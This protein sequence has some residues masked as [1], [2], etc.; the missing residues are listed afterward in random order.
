M[1]WQTVITQ[2]CNGAIHDIT[3]HLFIYA[4]PGASS[5]ITSAKSVPTLK[6][7]WERCSHAFPPYYT[8]AVA[9]VENPVMSAT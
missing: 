1:M 8:P 2:P 9:S 3:C 5:N 4:A 6:K 7:V